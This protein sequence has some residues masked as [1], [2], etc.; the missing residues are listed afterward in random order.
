[1]GQILTERDLAKLLRVDDTVVARLV[2][3]T[4]LPRVTVDGQLR[5]LKAGVIDWLGRQRGEILPPEPEPEPAPAPAA[6]TSLPSAAEGETPFVTSAALAALGAGAADPAKNLERLQVRDALLG[7][8]DALL[9]LLGRLGDGRLHPPQD[10]KHRTSGWRVDDPARDRV[11][12]IS[13]AWGEG[14]RAEPGF[15]DRPHLEVELSAG[16]LRVALVAPHGFSDAPTDAEVAELRATGLAAALHE[17]PPTIAKVYPLRLPAP[18][19]AALA[20]ALEGDLRR[21]VPLWK[22]S[23]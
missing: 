10:G 14:E 4:D 6:V 20:G 11:S 5:F 9:P 1:M 15:A 22:R 23:R 21:L 19:L 2:A 16:E 8:N 17:A 7:L 18:T 12:A 13:I 3:E